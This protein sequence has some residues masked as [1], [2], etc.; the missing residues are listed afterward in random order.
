MYT[1]DEVVA[2]AYVVFKEGLNVNI[3]IDFYQKYQNEFDLKSKSKRFEALKDVIVFE[4]RAFKLA[5]N[6][7][8]EEI[9]PYVRNE[10][11]VAFAFLKT[12]HHDNE[13]DDIEIHEVSME[14]NMVLKKTL[15]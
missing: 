2:S 4:E 10:L 1:Y 14:A 6:H 9:Y 5:P 12:K 3:I 15:F 8:I 13:Y 7:K 11:V